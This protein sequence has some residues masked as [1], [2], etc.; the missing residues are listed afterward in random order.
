MDTS[1]LSSTMKKNKK[2]L[3]LALGII[4][5]LLVAGLVYYL[6]SK[7]QQDAKPSTDAC[8]AYEAALENVHTQM[9][10]IV[11]SGC[12]QEGL[13]QLVQA[14]RDI[15]STAKSNPMERR[16]FVLSGMV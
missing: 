4:V 7:G 3:L 8:S 10:G 14:V 11:E 6:W 2:P 15:V 1:A 13:E 5:L 9:N 16:G 12:N